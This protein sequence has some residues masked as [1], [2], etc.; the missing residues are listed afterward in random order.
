[1]K[2]PRI[3]VQTVSSHRIYVEHNGERT[4]YAVTEK[5]RE[6]KVLVQRAKR[7]LGIAKGSG[8]SRD[9]PQGN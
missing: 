2:K 5:L 3:V 8:S 7:E 4:L 6:A 9:L 1:M